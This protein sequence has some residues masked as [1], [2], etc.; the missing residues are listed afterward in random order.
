MDMVRHFNPDYHYITS[1]SSSI[2]S[3]VINKIRE[4]NREELSIYF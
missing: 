1:R 2:A 3:I 4:D